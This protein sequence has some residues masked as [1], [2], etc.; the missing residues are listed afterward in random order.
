AGGGGGVE[1]VA[2]A[3]ASGTGARS[4]CDGGACS[5]FG[6]RTMLPLAFGSFGSFTTVT[7]SSCSPGPNATLVVPSP[8]A[9][10]NTCRSLPAGEIFRIFPPNHCA[11]YRLPLPSSFML[12][13]PSHHDVF[14][15]GTRRFRSAKFARWLSEPSSLIENLRM[16][17]PTVSLT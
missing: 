11:T 7:Y 5:A 14:L 12:S 10:G 6:I 9:I 13:G 3:N 2:D 8:A 1:G 17:F 15:F 4:E 16:Q